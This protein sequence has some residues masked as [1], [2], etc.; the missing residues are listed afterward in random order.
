MAAGMKS[1]SPAALNVL[2]ELNPLSRLM[3]L[4]GDKIHKIA[5]VLPSRSSE[6]LYHR[7][8]SMW[9]DPAEVVIGGDEPPTPL[10]SARASLGNLSAVERMMALD[11]ITYLPDDILCKLD[12]AAMS[13]SLET[14]VPLLDPE[15]VQFAWRLPLHLKLRDGQSKWVLRQLLY[16]YVPPKLI[17]RPKMG[18]AVPIGDWL[19]GP[20]RDWSEDLLDRDRLESEGYFHVG[21]VR[22]LWAQ[23]VSGQGNMQYPLWCVLMFQSWLDAQKGSKPD[24]AS[25]MASATASPSQEPLAI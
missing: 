5:A 8:V 17:E 1:L 11:L 25:T 12:R 4:P 10:S 22:R 24:S 14:R 20:L 16:R 3:S 2:G 23:H 7:L 9:Q 6:E 13:V 21:P 18:F 19:R 15:V